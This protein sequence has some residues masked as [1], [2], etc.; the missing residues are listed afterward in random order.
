MN[1]WD[2]RF[3][4]V[5]YIYGIEPNEFLKHNIENSDGK[6]KKILF[7][8][9]GEG[10]NAVYAAKLGFDV[11]AFDSSF[12]GREKA[13]KLAKQNNVKINY[14]ISDV[15]EINYENN[16]FDI[17]VLIYAHFPK[18]FRSQV[19]RKLIDLLKD[20]GQIILEAFNLNQLNNNSGGPKNIEM[21]YDEHIL[22]SDFK[23]LNTVLLE[24]EKVILDEG[25]YHQ[26]PAEVV[27]YIGKK[28]K[29]L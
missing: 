20:N 15:R 19:H 9:E 25:K 3:N 18:E 28:K 4:S 13:L 22:K 24:E 10:R 5:D 17:V 16:Y 21:L 11:Y 2:E 8:C 1:F 29:E 26:G 12:V 23:K 14:N 27:R 6:G 7:V